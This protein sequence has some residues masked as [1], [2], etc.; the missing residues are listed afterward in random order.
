MADVHYAFVGTYTEGDSE[1]IYTYLLDSE[2]ASL[3]H[4]DTTDAGP[5]PSFLAVH[6]NGEH[7]YAVNEID[8]GAVTALSIDRDSGES[9]ELNRVTTGGGAHPCHCTVDATGQF[10]LVAHYNGGTV[11]MV[12]ITDDGGV[13]EPS[14]LVE[15][16]GSGPHP[17]RQTSAHPH[18]IR[19]G[20]ENRFAYVPDLGT[21]EVYVYEMDL[22]AGK[23]R[24][25]EFGSLE[26]PGGSG[27]R[28]LDFHPD[29]DRIYLLNE[30]SSTLT[31]IE[32]DSSTGAL[33]IVDSEPTLPA[34]FDDHN[35][36]ADVHVHESGQWAYATNRGHDS[37][38][39]FAVDDA[40][41]ALSSVE[42]VS[43]RGEW[44]RHFTVTPSG[45]HLLVENEDTNDVVTFEID[46]DD[47][48]LSATGDVT[49]IP[50][51]V[52]VQFLAKE[53]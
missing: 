6:P 3:E 31:A 12:P 36:T 2:S 29:Y 19:P 42:R 43:T 46:S 53:Q 30:L 45:S 28:H 35:I 23:L 51:P 10:L 25:T 26:L 16:D 8:D 4:V 40:T 24:E 50:S 34:E 44:P 47:G 14:H 15:H 33:E 37:I 22:E 38:A 21:D 32:R 27:P 11:A 49:D 5:N 48:T 1:G 41:G 52:C 17:E 20:P 39:V 13:E 18:S 7:L 9:S